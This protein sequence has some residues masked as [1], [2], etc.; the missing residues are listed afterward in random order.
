MVT[1]PARTTCY[2]IAIVVTGPARTTYSTIS[3]VVAGSAHTALYVY[4]DIHRAP[5]IRPYQHY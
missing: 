4:V 2:T 3:V 5:P 1:G